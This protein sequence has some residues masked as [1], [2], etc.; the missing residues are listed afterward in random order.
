MKKKSKRLT[1]KSNLNALGYKKVKKKYK[2]SGYLFEVF[3]GIVYILNKF[4]N[5]ELVFEKRKKKKSD[6]FLDVNVFLDSI[7]L[8]WE[9]NKKKEYKLRYPVL[10]HTSVNVHKDYLKLILNSKKEYGFNLLYIDLGNNMTHYNLVFYDFK[11]KRIERFD[12]NYNASNMFIIKAIMDKFDIKFKSL[13]DK[14]GYEYIIPICLCKLNWQ[15]VEMSKNS[16]ISYASNLSVSEE[17]TKLSSDAE[18]YCGMWSILYAYLRL[19][20]PDILP[21]DLIYKIIII[22]K[23]KKIKF[24]RFIRDF[25]NMIFSEISTIQ[26]KRK[27]GNIHLTNLSLKSNSN[28]NSNNIKLKDYEYYFEDFL[29]PFLQELLND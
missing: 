29:L 11:N 10:K 6:D 13:L 9:T 25:T 14:I 7:T 3:V 22:L 12:P 2:Y 28:N 18:G 27:M 20:Y 26:K 1:N 8:R 4:K 23:K 21:N 15:D 19:L 17:N 5:V 24:R 16:L